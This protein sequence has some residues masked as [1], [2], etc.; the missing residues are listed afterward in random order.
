MRATNVETLPMNSD[1]KDLHAR[2]STKVTVT[3]STTLGK[4]ARNHYGNGNCWVYIYLANREAV[5]TPEKLTEGTELIL[6]ELTE[7]E[8]K[9]TKDECLILY[10][11]S[12]GAAQNPSNE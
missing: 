9:I 7:E 2:K 5:D 3:K 8:K 1:S 4:L 12:R 10:G 11:M 6:P